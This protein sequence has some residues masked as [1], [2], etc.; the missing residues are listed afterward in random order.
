MLNY[1]IRVYNFSKWNICIFRKLIKRGG[2]FQM[3]KRVFAIT[4]SVILLIGCSSGLKRDSLET[5]D[6]AVSPNWLLKAVKAEFKSSSLVDPKDITFVQ[7]RMRDIPKP[8]IL[9]Y[10]TMDRLNGLIILFEDTGDGYKAVYKR[11][12]PVYGVQVFGSGSNQVVAFTAGHGGTGIQENFF[13]VLGY[14]TEIYKELW[15]G[16]AERYTFTGALPYSYT[17]GAINLDMTNQS[18]IYTQYIRT[19]NKPQFDI[20]TPDLAETK[21]FYFIYD[22]DTGEYKLVDTR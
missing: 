19:Y 18:L 11:N 3:N 20:N 22:A 4:L 17:L 10:I 21:T 9:A 14:S 8:Q 7:V 5:A 6:N 1:I 12:E 16:A 15:K 13:Y 2:V